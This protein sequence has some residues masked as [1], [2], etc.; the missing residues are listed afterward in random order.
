MEFIIFDLEYTWRDDNPNFY[1]NEIIQVA[2]LKVAKLI[3][4]V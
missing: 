1:E 3:I 2:A 4:Q